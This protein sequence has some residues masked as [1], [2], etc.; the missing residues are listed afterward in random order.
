MVFP[1]NHKQAG[2]PNKLPLA[3]PGIF[4]AHDTGHWD[5]DGGTVSSFA[6]TPVASRRR[7]GAGRSVCSPLLLRVMASEPCGHELP[8]GGGGFLSSGGGW[9]VWGGQESP[10]GWRWLTSAHSADLPIRGAWW[11]RRVGVWPQLKSGSRGPGMEPTLGSLLSGEPAVH[12]HPILLSL[13][14]FLILYSL[15]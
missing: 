11:L 1:G 12:P 9:L 13:C 5:R 6:L 15:K 4:S 10:W 8:R 7:P 2:A 14:V 3:E